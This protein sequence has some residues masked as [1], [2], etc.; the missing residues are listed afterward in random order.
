[1]IK[2][3]LRKSIL[4]LTTTFLLCGKGY[5]DEITIFDHHGE[6]VA[7]VDT[8]EQ[9]TVFMWSGLPVAYISGNNIYGFNGK[10]LGWINQGIIYDHDG[11]GVGFFKNATT[12]LTQLESLKDLKQLKPLRALKELEPLQP[13]LSSYWTNT[14]LSIFLINGND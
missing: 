12:T 2:A 9:A 4:L 6:A 13:L 1:M 7:Y 3:T 10:H 14:P 8:N 11:N 5:A